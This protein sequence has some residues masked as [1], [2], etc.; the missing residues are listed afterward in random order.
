MLENSTYHHKKVEDRLIEMG[1]KWKQ[2][3]EQKYEEYIIK[4]DSR[5]H[6]VLNNTINNKVVPS[7]NTNADLSSTS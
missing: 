3:K 2:K 4:V 5:A 1:E 7:I 6:P